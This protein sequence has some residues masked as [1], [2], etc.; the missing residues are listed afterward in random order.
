MRAAGLAVRW[1]QMSGIPDVLED[2][3]MLAGNIYHLI[4]TLRHEYT[5]RHHRGRRLSCPLLIS[6]HEYARCPPFRLKKKNKPRSQKP[7]LLSDSHFKAGRDSCSRCTHDFFF[8]GFFFFAT[9]PYICSCPLPSFM[10]RWP[11]DCPAGP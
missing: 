8:S 5:R 4:R 10:P 1:E 11:P 3:D 2:V 6:L 9:L 7:T